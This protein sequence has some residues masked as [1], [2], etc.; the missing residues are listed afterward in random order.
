M[1]AIGRRKFITLLGGAAAASPI[2]AR[3]Q[4]PLPVIG[5][6]NPGSPIEWA[7]L[8]VAFKEG[9]AQTGYIEG[10]NVA[11][12]YRWGG[13]SYDRLPEMAADLVR[14]QVAVIATG[15]GPNTAFAAKAATSSIPIVFS[16]GTDPVDSGLVASLG[17]PDANLTGVHILTVLL[18]TKRQELLHEV[19][20]S[21]PTVAMLVNPSSAQ[22][23]FELPDVEA[24]G[25]KIGQSVRILSAGTDDEID[26]AFATIVRERIGGLLVQADV[27]FTSRRQRLVLLTTRHAIPTVF[28]WREFVTAG[29]LMSYGADLRAGYRLGGG[30][31]GQILKGAKTADL[32]VQQA[33][34]VELV[35]NLRA[36]K[37]LGIS[38]PLPLLG[39]ADEVIE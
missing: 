24:A 14:R 23:R 12:E 26:A 8:V 15:G 22:S 30:Y 6:L 29:G 38:L 28:A 13:D 3:A 31:V 5:F 20:P 32:P 17:R 36:A 1:V 33:T 9:L 11:I 19:V 35:I 2:V 27:F 25:A 10:K 37:V 16:T 21:V 18:S 39:R 7:H 4:Q 34:K